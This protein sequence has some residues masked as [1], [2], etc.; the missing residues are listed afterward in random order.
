MKRDNTKLLILLLCALQV[1]TLAQLHGVKNDLMHAQNSLRG[2]IG[3]V[4]DRMDN[5]SYDVRNALEEQVDP[6]LGAAC[7][8]RAS[9]IPRR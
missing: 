5:I 2:D 4:Q 9:P 8:M 1:A 3:V 7:R 6:I